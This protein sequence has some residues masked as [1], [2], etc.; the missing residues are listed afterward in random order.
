MCSLGWP[1]TTYVAK[2]DLEL[3]TFPVPTS[4]VTGLQVYVTTTS[5]K[6]FFDRFTLK[7]LTSLE[8]A[9]C[10]S[11]VLLH[12]R[13][14]TD[15][16]GP[17]VLSPWQW[18]LREERRNL[19]FFRTC[20]AHFQLSGS[21]SLC[22]A[23]GSGALT[24]IYQHHRSQLPPPPYPDCVQRSHTLSSDSTV[25]VGLGQGGGGASLQLCITGVQPFSSKVLITCFAQMDACHVPFRGP[26]Y[27]F[28]F[29]PVLPQYF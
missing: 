28:F 12:Y 25:S 29:P 18:V 24:K 14:E 26:I 15:R 8:V 21:E 3:L 9:S 7:I 17:L 20:M 22:S 23:A 27:S 16:R 1:E 10:G 6:Q 19:D 5:S 11:C 4:Q 2:D 13:L